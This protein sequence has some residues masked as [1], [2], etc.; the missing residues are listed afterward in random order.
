MYKKKLM[1]GLLSAAMVV[2]MIPVNPVTAS[3]EDNASQTPVEITLDKN[4]ANEVNPIGGFV[5]DNYL[6]GGDPAVLVDGDTVYLYEGHDTSKSEGYNMPEWVCYSTKDLKDWKYEGVV[7]KADFETISW[8][9][10]ESSA[11]AGQV[12]KYNNK[13]YFYYCCEDKGAGEGKSIGVAVSDSPTGPF[14]DKGEP[15]VQDSFTTNGTST[16][17]DID[18]TVWIETDS[19]GVEHRYLNWGNGKNFTCELNE[20]MMSI[21]DING[22]GEIKFGKQTYK[23]K[24]ISVPEDAD[25]VEMYVNSLKFTEAPWLYRRQDAEGN[26]YGDYYMF[27][28]YDWREQMAYATMSSDTDLF[29]GKWGNQKVI[30]EPT[31]TSNTNHMAVFDFQGK[32]YFIYH[33]G[34][35]P[36]GSGFRRSACITELTFNEDGSINYIPETTVGIWGKTSVIYSSAATALTHDTYN[37]SGADSDYPYTNVTVKGAENAESADAQWVLVDGKADPAKASYVSIQSENKPGLYLTVNDNKSV[38]LAQDYDIKDLENAAKK[39]TFKSVKGLADE[40][41][42]SFESVSQPGYYLTLLGDNALCVTSGSN[43]KASTFYL[44]EAPTVTP[45][46]GLASTNALKSVSFVGYDTKKTDDGYSTTIKYDDAT[47]SAVITLEDEKGYFTVDGVVG[48]SG[49]AASISTSKVSTTATLKIFAE[50]NTLVDTKTLVINKEKPVVTAMDL[51]SSVVA[52]YN[53]NDTTGD[54]FAVV[55]NSTAGNAPVVKENATYTYTDGVEGKAIVLDGTCGLELGESKLLGGNYSISFWMKPTEIKSNVDPIFAAGTFNPQHWLNITYKTDRAIWSYE[56]GYVDV[57]G[58]IEYNANE[59]QNVV[60]SVSGTTATLYVDGELSASGDIASGIM[61][62]SGSKLYFG[63]NGWDAYFKGAVDEIVLMNKAITINDARAIAYKYAT[64][65]NNMAYE[66]TPTTTITV[67][68]APGAKPDTPN[69]GNDNNNNNNN[70]NNNGTNNPAGGT[71][72]T[73]N[74]TNNTNNSSNGATTSSSKKKVTVAKV[75]SLKLAS[76]KKKQLKV[77]WKKASGISGY[78]IQYSTKK[79]FKSAKTVVVKKTKT[80]YTIKKLKSKKKY[81]VRIRAYKTVSGKKYYS[82]WV[83]TNKKVK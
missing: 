66:T 55:K 15:L 11:W 4:A 46:E 60:L 26:Y 29:H 6:Y 8:A 24:Q 77:S 43:A 20:D 50:D 51:S 79:N 16:W 74:A 5:D 30:M 78:Q 52:A 73:N 40:K 76:K 22:D 64:T 7:M 45:D 25:V 1:A 34:S 83:S 18:P 62:C 59:W 70:N 53:F 27:Y 80:S 2:T 48:M 9:Q 37:N 3:A 56:T 65:A 63:V 23:N 75:K 67:N 31:A 36:A 41:G 44:N 71:G 14:V 47:A 28:A 58:T 17:N 49:D 33:N 21:K 61:T 82:S 54:A 68:K 19:Q 39:Q 72:N 13:Y 57:A 32:T 12:T 38:T 42:V 35:L 69:N 10:D 81:Y